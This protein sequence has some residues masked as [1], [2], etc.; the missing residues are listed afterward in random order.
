MTDRLIEQLHTSDP[1]EKRIILEALYDH[2]NSDMVLEEAAQL[3]AD[4]DRGVREAASRVLVL[5]SSD[6]AASLTAPHISNTNI[7]VRNLAGDSLVRMNVAAVN[8]LLPYV[9]SADKDTRKF[10]IDLLA[11]LP[12]TLDAINR[13]AAR[14][15]DSDTNV[16]CA[17]IDALGALHARAYLGRILDMFDSAAYARPNIVN[18]V[19]K[20]THNG[21]SDFFLKALTDEDPVVQLAAAEALAA[22]KDPAVLDALLQK[23]DSVSELARPVVLHSIVILLESGDYSGKLSNRLKDYLIEM[24]DDIDPVYVRTA[25]RGLR[26][27]ID[28]KVL[29]ALIDHAGKADTID[30]AIVSV[31]EERPQVAV[32]LLLKRTSGQPN[33]IPLVKILITM[34]DNL[35]ARGSAE[36]HSDILEEVANRVSKDFYELDVETKTASM[37]TYSNLGTHLSMQIMKAALDDPEPSVKNYAIDLTT[38]LGPQFF[39]KQLERLTDD[40][41]QEVCDAA[42]AILRTM[43][44][45]YKEQD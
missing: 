18:A 42:A 35:V 41:D 12:A 8:S 4:D 30:R 39:L 6:K 44:Q 26:H 15:S 28:E 17:S 45:S 16:V 32:P 25:V 14:L 9:D 38:K 21:E 36:A 19:A 29:C 2:Y 23:L 37:N 1:S 7:A 10:A 22:R 34:I 40:S 13:I 27:F 31:M 3:L 24:L 33:K 20:L 5:A 11:Q 43:K